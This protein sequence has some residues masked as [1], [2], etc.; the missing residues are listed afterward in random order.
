MVIY[1][2]DKI[3]TGKGN[4]NSLKPDRAEQ[5]SAMLLS[6]LTRLRTGGSEGRLCGSHSYSPQKV[7]MK[8]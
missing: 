1:K 6:S 8:Q 5:A 3:C 4:N 7:S 2:Y